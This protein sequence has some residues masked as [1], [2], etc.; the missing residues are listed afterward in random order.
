MNQMTPRTIN[1]KTPRIVESGE[2]EDWP[3]LVRAAC[4]TLRRTSPQV[5]S[6][7]SISCRLAN[8]P[9]EALGLA[10]ISRGL[11]AE[12][13]LRE[14]VSVDGARFTLRLARRASE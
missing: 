6:G 8:L 7:I 13:D 3:S 9:G 12:Y 10:T 2:H 4:L 11:A 1:A 5:I 14:S